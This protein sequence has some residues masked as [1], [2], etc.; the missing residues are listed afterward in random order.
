M[1]KE[2]VTEQQLASA[3]FEMEFEVEAD[4]TTCGSCSGPRQDTGH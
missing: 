2:N 1:E 3:E 4:A